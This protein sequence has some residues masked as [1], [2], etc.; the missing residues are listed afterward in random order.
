MTCGLVC[1]KVLRIALSPR[2][3]RNRNPQDTPHTFPQLALLCL[4]GLPCQAK[5]LNDFL[6][7]ACM[8]SWLCVNFYAGTFWTNIKLSSG[9]NFHLE[10]EIKVVLTK[11]SCIW[12]SVDQF[13]LPLK[14]KWGFLEDSFKIAHV[15]VRV[16]RLALSY[17]AYRVYQKNVHKV[18]QA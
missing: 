5:S 9:L 2:V 13:R 17:P 11:T 14:I 12:R 4:T 1:R 16:R 15:G 3:G 18:N 8:C 7:F 10:Q 6:K